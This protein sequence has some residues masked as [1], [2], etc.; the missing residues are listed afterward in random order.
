MND[1]KDSRF[2]SYIDETELEVKTLK[3]LQAFVYFS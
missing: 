1:A 3:I 2:K